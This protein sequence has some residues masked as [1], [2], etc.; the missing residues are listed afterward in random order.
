MP[1][2]SSYPAD[3]TVTDNDLFIGSDVGDGLATKTYSAVSVADYLF[4]TGRF[5]ASTYT[6]TQGVAST[7][8]TITHNLQR[9]P[10]VSIVDTGGNI[11]Y[12]HTQYVD[13]NQITLTFSSAF[14]GKAYLN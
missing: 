9:H 7:T 12:G 4:G 10:S 11:I 2:I 14:T 13:D 5:A 3:N 6:H 1:R 8:W